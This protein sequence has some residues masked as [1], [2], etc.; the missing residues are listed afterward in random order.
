MY[1]MSSY[2]TGP[3]KRAE[4]TPVD[5]KFFKLAEM[6]E[7]LQQEDEKE[8]RQQQKD[9]KQGEE[10][11]DSEEEEESGDVDMFGELPSDEEEEVT[12]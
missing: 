3:T 2:Q 7:F 10:T 9:A 11:S 12:L 1:K 5:D 4:R 8:I 6:E